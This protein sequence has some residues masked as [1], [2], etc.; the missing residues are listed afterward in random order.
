MK[1]M[2]LLCALLFLG[3]GISH[4]A[5]F[6]VGTGSTGTS[7]TIYLDGLYEDFTVEGFYVDANA[8]ISAV[9]LVLQ[10][11]IDTDTRLGQWHDLATHVF[12]AGEITGKKAMYHV[13]SKPVTRVR[14]NLSTLT[15]KDATDTVYCI[16]R[17]YKK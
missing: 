6:S 5:D 17:V 2:L 10:G 9:T 12:T 1:K 13:I 4:A 14:F 3:F 11:A 7:D 15:G 8:S 16:V